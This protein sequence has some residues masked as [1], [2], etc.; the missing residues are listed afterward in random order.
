MKKWVLII[1]ALCMTGCTTA[2]HL[3]SNKSGWFNTRFIVIDDIVYCNVTDAGIPFCLK[4]N[5]IDDEPQTTSSLRN[6]RTKD[7]VD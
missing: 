4:P 7:S 5:M 1:I 2:S 3:T 6:V